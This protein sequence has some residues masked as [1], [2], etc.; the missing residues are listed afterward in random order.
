MK[1]YSNANELDVDSKLKG[2]LD[3]FNSIEDFKVLYPPEELGGKRSRNPS[4]SSGYGLR[5]GGYRSRRASEGDE[6]V[7]NRVSGS[8]SRGG[9][10]HN[11]GGMGTG[12]PYRGRYSDQ[13]ESNGWIMSSSYQDKLNARLSGGSSEVGR[14]T[15]SGPRKQANSASDKVVTVTSKAD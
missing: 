4:T 1:Y 10:R 7:S 13:S 5:I 6:G 2:Q 15:P 11:S 8:R 14:K 9:S 3:Q 12:K